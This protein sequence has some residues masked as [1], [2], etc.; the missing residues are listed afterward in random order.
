MGFTI[1]KW[2]HFHSVYLL[3]VY[4]QKWTVNLHF[5]VTWPK[6]SQHKHE[7]IT[8]KLD[9]K[10]RQDKNQLGFKNQISNNQL[11]QISL[12]NRQDK[13]NLTLRTKMIVTKNVLKVKF[14]RISQNDMTNE[15]QQ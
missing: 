3:A 11:D 9:F 2:P 7:D 5:R 8:V 10:N 13:N 12:K 15:H 1:S 14:H 4:K 6:P